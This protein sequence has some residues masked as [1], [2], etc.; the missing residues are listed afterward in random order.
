MS[1]AALNA[2]LFNQAIQLGL[3]PQSGQGGGKGR[4]TNYL[5]NLISSY[6]PPTPQ[7]PPPP[8]PPPPAPQAPVDLTSGRARLQTGSKASRK[9]R[10]SQ[11]R[12][13]RQLSLGLNAPG[14]SAEG[15]ISF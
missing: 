7:A 4:F 14:R 2:Q 12:S 9:R 3:N 6:Q 15:G 10:K 1:R 8:P 5:Q 13:K 11:G